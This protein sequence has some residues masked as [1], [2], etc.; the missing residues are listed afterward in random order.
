MDQSKAIET[1]R[2]VLAQTVGDGSKKCT[3]FVVRTFPSIILDITKT[4][5]EIASEDAKKSPDPEQAISQQLKPFFAFSA[6]L[7]N[8]PQVSSL[9]YRYFKESSFQPLPRRL[10]EVNDQSNTVTY[11]YTGLNDD[12]V[13][14]ILIALVKYLTYDEPWFSATWNWAE[15]GRLIVHHPDLDIRFLATC[16]SSMILKPLRSQ[17]ISFMTRV[18]DDDYKVMID[19]QIKHQQIFENTYRVAITPNANQ[20]ASDF[21][22][23]MGLNNSEY[24][25][26][27][28]TIAKVADVLLLKLKNV[29]A[30]S[31]DLCQKV[32]DNYI[33][34]DKLFSPLSD[35][36]YAISINK[37]CLIKGPIGSGKS[38]AIDFLAART[39]RVA[40][41]N[42]V[43]VQICD[44]IDS[45]LLIGNYVSTETPGH[46]EWRPG[47]LTKAMIDGSW[48]V[49]EDIDSASPEIT[50][51]LHSVIENGNLS[52][53]SCCPIQLNKPHPDF[54]ILFTQKSGHTSNSFR[55][56]EESCDTV[57]LPELDRDDLITV[58]GKRFQLSGIV[59]TLVKVYYACRSSMEDI[60][61]AGSR[62]CRSLN[63]RDLFKLC[64]RL[65]GRIVTTDGK[66][67]SSDL[68]TL[69]LDTV[70]CFFSF[71]PKELL[72]ELSK[73]LGSM[74][75]MPIN[76]IQR[77]MVNRD[78]K[79]SRVDKVLC[80]GRT[81]VRSEGVEEASKT[82]AYTSQALKLMEGIVTGLSQ[83][84]PILLVG[85]TGVGKTSIIQHVSDLLA[86]KLVVLN[87]SQQSDSSD[88]LGNYKPVDMRDL[89]MPLHDQFESI[90]RRTY[91]ADSNRRFLDE[92]TNLYTT[93]R[94]PTDWCLYT[95]VILKL[96]AR[97][98]ASRLESNL[99]ESWAELHMKSKALSSRLS[100]QGDSNQ[101]ALAFSDG[102]LLAAIK[103]G[104]WILLDEL[105]LAEPDV[106]QCLLLILDTISESRTSIYIPSLTQT[107]KIHPK[108]RIFACMNPST[109]IG[110]RE[111][112][113]SVRARFTEYFV[114]DV[115]DK[116]DLRLI[117][118]SYVKPCL[119][120][121]MIEKIVNFYIEIR[122]RAHLYSDIAGN[123][124]VYSLR[125][126]CRALSMCSSNAC[127]AIDKSLFESIKVAFIH[128][129][130]DGSKLQF[131]KLIEQYLFDKRSLEL[132][133]KTAIPSPRDGHH[134]M[135]IEGFWI[136]KSNETPY[137]DPKYIMTDTIHKNL[138]CLVRIISLSQRRLPIL[139]QGNTSVGKTSLVMH[140]AKSTG[141]RCFRI[142]N[143]EHTDLQEYV[144]RY[145]LR[146]DGEIIF[147]EGLL[148]KAMRKGY[149]IILDEL[150]L[151]P[152][153]LLE[154]LNRVLDDNRELY[155]PE[156]KELIKAHSKFILFATQN[157][158]GEYAGRKFLSR[159]FRNRFAELHFRDLPT[160]ELEQI[161]HEKC[162]MP[163]QYA[164]KIVMV[165]A[166]LQILRR[167]SG[168]FNGKQSF[169]T[170]RDLLRW[171]E[172]YLKFKSSF[173]G[174]TFYDWEHYLAVEGLMLLEGRVRSSVEADVV[175]NVIQKVFKRDLDRDSI[176][177]Q[178]DL[179][180]VN[181][182]NEFSHIH[183]S[184][185]FRRL[186]LRLTK[187]LKYKEPV[188][189]CGPTGCGKT[190]AC[191][192][193]AET[194][195][196]PIMIYNCHMGTESS[197]F[198]G[199]VRPSR[200]DESSKQSFPWVDGPLVE[201]MKRGGLFLMDEIS[202]ADDAV[203][204]RI[205]SVLEPTRSVTLTE[206]N[207]EEIYANENF[208]FVAT[209]NPGGDYGKKE[210]SPA[211][212]NRFTEIYC[213]ETTDLNQ[214]LS[215]I[216]A[217]LPTKL[218][219]SSNYNKVVNIKQKFLQEFCGQGNKISIRDVI[220]W[221]EFFK[222][223]TKSTK[224][225][226][227]SIQE[228][229]LNGISLVFFDRFGTC[230]YENLL[231]EGNQQ[232]RTRLRQFI[233]KEIE[234]NLGLQPIYLESKPIEKSVENFVK[235]KKFFLKIG[236]VPIP[237]SMHEDFI[238]ESPIV[239]K[240][241]L[242][243]VR[244]MQLNKP[245]LLE[246]DPGVGKTST[247]N[248]LAK[249]TGHKLVRINLSEQTDIIDLFGSD[250]PDSTNIDDEN[251]RFRW[252]DGPFLKAM[253]D[254]SWILLDEMNLASQ[255]VLEGLNSCL[256]HRGEI[257]IPELNKRFKVDRSE[258]RIFAC[259]NPYNKGGSRK[260]LPQS[261]LN[262]FTSI[263][264]KS[265]SAQDMSLI[266][267]RLYPKLPK[268]VPDKMVQFTQKVNN[269]CNDLGLEFN[270]RN[271]IY[272]S[273]LTTKYL[274]NCDVGTLCQ[275]ERFVQFAFL[276]SIRSMT[277]KNEIVEAYS[278]I[279][280]TPVYEPPYRE[281]RLG[282]KSLSIARSILP[283]RYLLQTN[284]YNLC[285]LKYQMPYLESLAKA[286]EFGKMPILIG[287]TG[288]GK[289]SMVKILA[290]LS[291][292][293]LNV[294]GANR[295]MDTTE[296]LGSFEQRNIQREIRDLLYD[297]KIFV[298]RVLNK[299]HDRKVPWDQIFEN[300]WSSMYSSCKN[301]QESQFSDL[302]ECYQGPLLQLK[303]LLISIKPLSETREQLRIDNFIICIDKLLSRIETS[304]S[305]LITGRFDWID[306]ILVS[307]MKDGAW[308]LIE[309][310]N[311]MNPATLDRLNSLVEPGGYLTLNEKG[312]GH[313]GVEI[314]KPHPNF[315]LILT[316][317]PENGELSRAMRNRGIEIY[318]QTSFFFEDFLIVL[319][320]NGFEPEEKKD[321]LA[322]CIMKTCYDFHNKIIDQHPEENGYLLTNFILN[323][324]RLLTHSYLRGADLSKVLANLLIEHYQ[325]YGYSMN[326][327][328][329]D[330]I[331]FVKNTMDDSRKAFSQV[332]LAEERFRW[333]K[334]NHDLILS[335]NGDANVAMVERD[336]RI[337][338]DD[339]SIED[340]L[341]PDE[342]L[343]NIDIVN[344]CLAV[345]IFLELSTREDYDYRLSY[346]HQTF[347]NCENLLNTISKHLTTLNSEYL[348]LIHAL[349]PCSDKIPSQELAIDTRN[350]PD[351][352]YYLQCLDQEATMRRQKF[353]NRW[354][355]S[356]YKI[357]MSIIVELT[358][359]R[360]L[361]NPGMSSLW[362]QSEKFIAGEILREHLIRPNAEIASDLDDLLNGII[363]V[364]SD[365]CFDDEIVAKMI[366]RLFWIN[367]FICKLRRGYI[368][369]ELIA[370]SNQLPMLWALTYQKV[371]VPII[372]DCKLAD[373]VYK[374]KKFSSRI[375]H[376]CNFFE[377]SIKKP[378]KSERIHYRKI[379]NNYA[380]A[381]KLCEFIYRETDKVYALLVSRCSN[382][383][384]IIYTGPDN[385][386]LICATGGLWSNSPHMK[387]LRSILDDV[388]RIEF[389]QRTSQ[390]S[391][392]LSDE[393]NELFK[394]ASEK[395]NDQKSSLDAIEE[396]LRKEPTRLFIYLHTGRKLNALD[397]FA[398]IWQFKLLFPK[399]MNILNY[400]T[401]PEVFFER[402]RNLLDNV[403]GIVV[404]PRLYTCLMK[405]L[406]SSNFDAPNPLTMANM[407][408]TY[409]VDLLQESVIL[410][411][412]VVNWTKLRV[413]T[414]NLSALAPLI[415][416]YCPIIS[417]T[418]SYSLDVSRLKLNSY[419]DSSS[420]LDM[421]LLHLWRNYV[422]C[423]TFDGSQIPEF[424]FARNLL[425][426]RNAALDTPKPPC[427]KSNCDCIDSFIRNR[428][429]SYDNIIGKISK[430]LNTTVD[431]IKMIYFGYLNCLDYAPLFT[432]D[433]SVRAREKLA[434]YNSE[435]AQIKLDLHN[436][437]T[438]YYW[439]TGENLRLN[440]IDSEDAADYTFSTKLL[441]DRR[442][443]L[444][445]SIDKLLKEHHN[446]PKSDDGAVY[447][448]LRKEVEVFLQRCNVN[449]PSLI[450]E[451]VKYA[452]L[453]KSNGQ[454]K[455]I[456]LTSRCRLMIKSFEKS[457]SH[458]KNEYI[459]YSDLLTN[460]LSA[461]CL[462]HKGL[463]RLYS[464]L[465]QDMQINEIGL[466]QTF[467]D[468]LKNLFLF[469]NYECFN[470]DLIRNKLRFFPMIEK[471]CPQD[472][473]SRIQSLFLRNILAQI[474]HQVATVPSD[475]NRCLPIVRRIADMYHATWLKRKTYIE[476]KRQEA[477]KGYKYKTYRTTLGTEVSFEQQE[478]L[479]LCS[480]F[481][482]YE[483]LYKNLVAITTVSSDEENLVTEE[484]ITN[485]NKSADLSLCNDV[486]K[487]YYK[488][489]IQA[490]QSLLSPVA[491]SDPEFLPSANL[492]SIIEEEADIL[493]TIVRH[494]IPSLDYKF[495]S[496][497]VEYHMFQNHRM[498]R[499]L[500]DEQP[501]PI[502][503]VEIKKSMEI[504]DVD[505][506]DIYHDPKPNEAL[507]F[508]KFL[509][510]VDTRINIIQNGQNGK[511]YDNHPI[512]VSIIKLLDRISSFLIIDPLMKFVTGSH[513]LLQK[514]EEWNQQS[515][516]K[517]DKLSSETDD[518]IKI[519][520]SWRDIELK[521][522]QNSLHSVK[523]RFINGTLCDLWFQLYEAFRDPV[524]CSC[525]LIR[526]ADPNFDIKANEEYAYLGFALFIKN[527][528]E[529]STLGDHRL[530]LDLVYSFII[531]SRFGSIS[532]RAK[533]GQDDQ[534][535]IDFEKLTIYAYNTYMQYQT[536]F[537]CLDEILLQE[538]ANFTN[539]LNTEIRVVS[540]QG[541]NLWEIKNNFRISH[542]K[543]NSVLTR[544]LQVL[545][546]PIPQLGPKRSLYVS[547]K[548]PVDSESLNQSLKTI[549]TL[550]EEIS[551][552]KLRSGK[553]TEWIASLDKSVTKS[554]T[555]CHAVFDVLPSKYHNYLVHLESVL[556]S[557][558]DDIGSFYNQKVNEVV[559]GARDS[560]EVRHKKLKLCREMHH[561]RRFAL[562]S[563]FKTLRSLGL[564]YQRGLLLA[565]TRDTLILSLEP[566]RG[567]T[568]K[569]RCSTSDAQDVLIES[570]N[571][572]YRRAVA[573]SMSIMAESRHEDLDSDQHSRIRGLCVDLILDILK[574]NGSASRIY[575]RYLD[576][577]TAAERFLQ[578]QPKSDSQIVCSL[579][580]AQIISIL[581]EFDEIVGHALLS[582][583]RLKEILEVCSSA[584]SIESG[585]PITNGNPASQELSISS[586]ERSALASMILDNSEGQCILTPKQFDHIQSTLSNAET[587]INDVNRELNEF[588]LS[589]ESNYIFCK[590]DITLIDNLGTKFITSLSNLLDFGEENQ[591]MRPGTILGSLK[592]LL[593]VARVLSEK[594][595][596]PNDRVDEL[597][598]HPNID[599]LNTRLKKLIKHIKL[600]IQNIYKFESK[601]AENEQGFDPQI[602]KAYSYFDVEA[603]ERL[604]EIKE[605]HVQVAKI[606]STLNYKEGH[607][608]ITD[609]VVHL[610]PLLTIYTQNVSAYLAIIFSSLNVKLDEA[611]TV[612]IF[613]SDLIANGFGLPTKLQDIENEIGAQ[614]KQ[615][616]DNV[617]FGEGQGSK[618]VSKKLEA[619]SQLDELKKDDD[620]DN[621]DGENNV[622]G[623]DDG[624]EMR[625]DI[626]GKALGPEDSTNHKGEDED[627]NVSDEEDEITQ[628]LDKEI[629]KCDDAEGQLD[630]KLW[631]D[632]ED[633]PGEDD[634][635]DLSDARSGYQREEQ[636][637]SELQ[638]TD[639]LQPQPLDN[640]Q[641][642]QNKE[643]ASSDKVQE[644]DEITANDGKDKEDNA[645]TDSKG[646]NDEVIEIDSDEEVA[647]GETSE[648]G[649]RKP[650]E[651]M[652]LTDVSS[653]DDDDLDALG[654]ESINK[655]EDTDT[656]N[657]Q[658]SDGE[659]VE[660][661]SSDDMDVSNDENSR[662]NV[663]ADRL[664]P[665]IDD[666]HIDRQLETQI[667][668][669]VHYK[670]LVNSIEQL[671]EERTRRGD[672][673]S[674]PSD[675]QDDNTTR[676]GF[677]LYEEDA[678][679][680]RFDDISD[681]DDDSE[682]NQGST[683]HGLD[684]KH[685]NSTDPQETPEEKLDE[686]RTSRQE[687]E[688]NQDY[689]RRPSKRNPPVRAPD[690]GLELKRKKILNSMDKKDQREEIRRES[691]T[692]QVRHTNIVNAPEVV[693]LVSDDED[694]DQPKH[695][696]QNET[697]GDQN[698][699]P[700]HRE[701]TKNIGK[702]ESPTK[703]DSGQIWFK[704]LDR[705]KH[706]VY[707]L[708][709][710]LQIVLQPT[711]M[712][713][714]RGD[715]KTGKRLNMRKIVSY[716]ASNYRKDK[717]WLRR[718]KPSKR[719]YNICIAV[720]NS[721]SM[722]ENNC[723]Q[724]T[725]E[726]LALLAKSLSIVEAGSLSVLSFGERVNCIHEFDEPYH[727]SV[728]CKWL[729]DLQFN[730]KRT[731]YNE[732]LKF[733][734]E[735]FDKRSSASRDSRSNTVSQLMIIISDGRNVS[736]E[737]DQLKQYL[738][739]LKE[740]KVIT[741]FVVIDDLQKNGGK[742]IVDIKRP[743]GVG[744]N[745]IMFNFMEL[746]PFPHYVL[747]RKI[748]LM[749]AVLGDALRQWFELVNQV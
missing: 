314:I 409:L 248:A 327:S 86:N 281:L 345:R 555:L 747:L 680:P 352:H 355:F 168:C 351:I 563:I 256:D 640:E 600:A 335:N 531:Q 289:R 32:L 392:N 396:A 633:E 448:D 565:D 419:P 460:F 364:V 38:S 150:N 648:E 714:Y 31:K 469:G 152:S 15:L 372:E 496:I 553:S 102:P 630:E 363:R 538:E 455:L 437:N 185:D 148:V 416:E 570:C 540:W 225:R 324:V 293:L 425:H 313:E 333:M 544:Y 595:I 550:L 10:F 458:L 734:C 657:E 520:K 452:L 229:I 696:Q 91:D 682:K 107:I 421:S 738:K 163:S 535:I 206:R 482:T 735:A 528:L 90:F 48:I 604:L 451:L 473:V 447:S 203:L 737:E 411:H 622:D 253:R 493:Y 708:C 498:I 614:F 244:A 658:L 736:H 51:V 66:F 440:E 277:L 336:N 471:V 42:Y 341:K 674:G 33:I 71:L 679:D 198:I 450:D 594:V 319:S 456:N 312:S 543:L 431:A 67:N 343:D 470:M 311:L 140:L 707:E 681:V 215:I 549:Q 688:I 323:S 377:I 113:A 251:P 710:Q 718:T 315:R 442:I 575:Q 479:D 581:K 625:D 379:S 713:K 228:A 81:K 444:K 124:P 700:E 174:G 515:I 698:C 79:I 620:N 697:T 161:L 240:N 70:D 547:Q 159:A 84:E 663:K 405:F 64:K 325:K 5:T 721:S 98:L 231:L 406:H 739:T 426:L 353:Q 188:L 566:V 733:A 298:L 685:Q 101:I 22:R 361:N 112:D 463:R 397:Q 457:I 539:I 439:R 705:C 178:E 487:T 65:S 147:Q 370:V 342:M 699:K 278:T 368:R 167:E 390:E 749:P 743:L 129:L 667:E 665:T 475:I 85:E 94:K 632:Q 517:D 745:M 489:M 420:Q 246:G 378:S 381:N 501:Q 214:I 527:F 367:H 4:L 213:Q 580:Y 296:L 204:E 108:F 430:T 2:H 267:E 655:I 400:L 291:G 530:R 662:D 252:C 78:V 173:D 117:V 567:L 120:T 621:E 568:M 532:L 288:V 717:I 280:S 578:L 47:P 512:L 144:G 652:D 222:E 407:Y 241:I 631:S 138:Q 171:G 592:H 571:E 586:M 424:E 564:S 551:S 87:L 209:M 258:S 417:L 141:N 30:Q 205:N 509:Q 519:I 602:R 556:S 385:V 329:Q 464:I 558:S 99:V 576:L 93:S 116:R 63:Q 154:A 337:F 328:V 344:T 58:I 609:L 224:P 459:L 151:A 389:Y 7:G 34:T 285:I 318:V 703:D 490:S 226:T 12:I 316:I 636:E 220:T 391:Q 283:R 668:F 122:A 6:L 672:T 511:S 559:I 128:Q 357:M 13:K 607:T 446:R 55:F 17:H 350:F 483:Y 20:L 266:I 114:D 49:F 177:P 338:F 423:K 401:K 247:V 221:C 443:K 383:S 610:S 433:P 593:D 149:W 589:S 211:L 641:A 60:C 591:N 269:L 613:F 466:K 616:D 629:S 410:D 635:L 729:K 23:S 579:N 669:P 504:Y 175:K 56:I 131:T 537:K 155:I 77:L 720:D 40:P 265:H 628:D 676:G 169:M 380:S 702:L 301:S 89:M 104:H 478:F 525:D 242:K 202:L 276:D 92:V 639:E 649:A 362:Q 74:L 340:I 53:V 346:V 646:N 577:Q 375:E 725:Y 125:T 234:K 510:K 477:E 200:S 50:Q 545:Q 165:M 732:L 321:C 521:S 176:Y 429:S 254:S 190:T 486:C 651:S 716:V 376:I 189:L 250:L 360:S 585:V 690:E 162:E 233:K 719:T 402:L 474:H 514:L 39:N 513:S 35:I 160:K 227:L 41:P 217:S 495:D 199:N 339:F 393:M 687:S 192:L 95:K 730:E 28:D 374:N 9:M 724:M 491:L 492:K 526:N 349:K 236:S 605:V 270:L 274:E 574:H 119:T 611:N 320:Q 300:L 693:D 75:N 731:S 186:F 619:E 480:R 645:L 14:N 596:I 259:Q 723:R 552:P 118:E 191:Q 634:E 69:F 179:P 356:L 465:E 654:D 354:L 704:C 661:D 494:C 29:D 472:E 686:D 422:S 145:V 100:T 428:I 445:K 666:D 196:M 572:K 109:D 130:D 207:G 615:N 508:Q 691:L 468:D 638:G 701:S 554:K 262:R 184:R 230:G 359:E 660:P 524:K 302:V 286:I 601:G 542:R 741:F 76:E 461:A 408:A 303:D 146:E 637:Q 45:K 561:S 642:T 132:L 115:L 709:Q 82:M 88:L 388:L 467:Q 80:F 142:N 670:P 273:D 261:F 264:I 180:Y 516:P 659:C 136:Q 518:L 260:G 8:C 183:F 197:D 677:T 412:Q 606:F 522:W 534:N 449:V 62:G 134:Y 650:E 249:I 11:T 485:L 137:C 143:H 127:G 307:S 121:N 671:I 208:R 599:R 643:L 369:E 153:E 235:F 287:D 166:E 170:M 608:D 653:I 243:L 272:W 603:I 72:L 275:P 618:D 238:T 139:I 481:P 334:F 299:V 598:K 523:K 432:I 111:L 310:A 347:A 675:N 212:R 365:R 403:H 644:E 282:E 317:N 740:L 25:H 560:K 255:S 106:L 194:H 295:D 326:P 626:G 394:L 110:K 582:I 219:T 529:G 546:Q 19:L 322:Y 97:A 536:L 414:C 418:A 617:G 584:N 181:S 201:S 245:I 499:M 664:S 292:N 239:K 305:S 16:C 744:A 54:R 3:E 541:R 43:K 438:L 588:L 193:F 309:D 1:A 73:K 627:E 673:E 164:K 157:P 507:R 52:C 37:P 678:S 366:P 683:G 435:L 726:S 156:T 44:Q 373:L 135:G 232:L 484:K 746:F 304:Q 332:S 583:Q 382:R 727:D 387:R 436:R 590:D 103:K 503:A 83:R 728:G 218:I 441:V 263:H 427:L 502:K 694:A 684:G 656:A 27:Q 453:V 533:D 105:N 26:C 126:L 271:I 46:F 216:K 268:G 404:S 505:V 399:L 371:L 223:T 306:S 612:L 330:V 462:V 172:R 623:H 500:Q 358:E 497:G 624:V 96:C 187:A 21:S 237:I 476:K 59:E 715:Y 413:T 279:F 415:P 597:E 384:N 210:L 68:D 692:N 284:I 24:P 36:A 61:L 488:L 695:V 182:S 706:L 434:V 587:T 123:V 569:K 57:N 748:E 742:S 195:K 711:K 557:S 647:P 573:Q 395:V 133:E 18:C 506:F 548:G 348:P 331:N 294:M 158:P 562:Q 290:S 386:E 257:F 722:S 297:A 398:P 689:E 454:Q 308:L 712:S